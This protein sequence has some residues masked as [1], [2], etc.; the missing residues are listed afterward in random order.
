MK[1]KLVKAANM[2]KGCGCSGVYKLKTPAK[3][4]MA[5]VKTMKRIAD[6][7]KFEMLEEEMDWMTMYNQV[8][9]A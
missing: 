8:T 4:M 6:Y 3:D 2:P 5:V 9:V 1:C 7:H